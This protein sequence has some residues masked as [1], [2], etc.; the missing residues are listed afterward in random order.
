MSVEQNIDCSSCF[1]V[2]AIFWYICP[3]NLSAHI[4]LPP[5]FL[6][7]SQTVSRRDIDVRLAFLQE[8]L[9]K[10]SDVQTLVGQLYEAF[11]VREYSADMER[12]VIA[13]L[14]DIRLQLVPLEQVKE[15]FKRPLPVSTI[16]RIR[17]TT[18]GLRNTLCAHKS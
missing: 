3:F 6:S 14:E 16:L 4:P 7:L 18:C 2:Y 15:H 8:N 12:A 17:I 13:E 5:I 9:Q 10:I 1:F 11:H